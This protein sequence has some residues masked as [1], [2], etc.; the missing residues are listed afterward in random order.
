[1]KKKARKMLVV[2]GLIGS[3]IFLFQSID[4]VSA[5]DPDYPTKPITCYIAFGAGDYDRDLR[6][7]NAC[8]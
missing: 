5:K 1:M 7:Q 4:S 8:E 3:L 2:M 6:D